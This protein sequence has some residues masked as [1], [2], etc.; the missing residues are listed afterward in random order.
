MAASGLDGRVTCSR[1]ALR[2]LLS[3]AQ[4]HRCCYCGIALCA[5]GTA[6]N[7]ETLEHVIAVAAGGWDGWL[8]TVAACHLCNQGRGAM[9]AHSYFDLVLKF[10][11]DAAHAKGRAWYRRQMRRGPDGATNTCCRQHRTGPIYRALAT[12]YRQRLGRLNVDA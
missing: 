2:S 3:E 8:N 6:H 5:G 7:S 12:A 11:R 4:G 1:A 9:L 10:G